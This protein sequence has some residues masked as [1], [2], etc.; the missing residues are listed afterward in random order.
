[1][2]VVIFSDSHGKTKT[3]E[4]I[5]RESKDIDLIFHLGDYVRDAQYL[6]TITDIPVTLVQGNCDNVQSPKEIIREI[7][8][9]RI[10]LTH[11]H[12]YGI[13]MGLNRLFYAAKEN[14]IDIVFFGHSH[15]PYCQENDGILFVNPGSIGDKRWQNNESYGVLSINGDNIEIQI[16]E[17]V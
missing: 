4:A 3:M 15:I 6:E 14:N 2:K 11:G 9:K 12:M 16:N 8:G 10:M 7:M 17:V 5:L 1:M 13:K